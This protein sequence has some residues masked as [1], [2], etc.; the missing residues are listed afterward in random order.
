M[1]FIHGALASPGNFEVPAGMLASRGRAF[2]APAYGQRGTGDITQSLEHLLGIVDDISSP[3][4]DIVG[5]S[6]GGLLGLQIAQQRPGRVRTLVG[7]GACFRGV[8]RRLRFPRLMSLVVGPTVV[9]L[10][11]TDRFGVDVPAGTSVFSIVSDADA[12]VPRSSSELG[13]VIPVHGIRHER[14]PSLGSEV[15]RALGYE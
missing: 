6:L 13:T 3:Q 5:H 15:L 11:Q 1:L 9:Q 12:V 4:L 2:L 14:L 10:T 8:P 7:L